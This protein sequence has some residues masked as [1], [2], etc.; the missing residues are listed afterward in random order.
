MKVRKILKNTKIQTKLPCK[1][2]YEIF[3]TCYISAFFRIQR[4]C[5][6]CSKRAPYLGNS[7]RPN[8]PK[9][10]RV[11]KV[12]LTISLY[13]LSSCTYFSLYIALFT[14]FYFLSEILSSLSDGRQSSVDNFYL[15]KKKVTKM[16]KCKIPRKN[17]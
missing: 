4:K 9:L 14:V 8:S 16:Q 17:F 15:F 10:M 13:S 2:I 11:Y 6:T 12:L 3:H 7:N 1:C 5:P